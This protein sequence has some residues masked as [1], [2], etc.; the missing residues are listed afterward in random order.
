MGLA[1]CVYSIVYSSRID[2]LVVE[3]SNL[4]SRLA[5]VRAFLQENTL[6]RKMGNAP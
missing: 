2:T 3:L 4:F 6:M 1:L 5:F